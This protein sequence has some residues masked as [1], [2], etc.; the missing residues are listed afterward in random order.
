MVK[1][2]VAAVAGAVAAMEVLEVLE[3]LMATATAWEVG[4]AAA[5]VK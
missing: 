3:V 1:E 5:V 4:L 2:R